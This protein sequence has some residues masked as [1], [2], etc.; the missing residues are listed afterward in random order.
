MKR[1]AQHLLCMA[2]LLFG[3]GG[4][5]Q[6]PDSLGE[7]IQSPQ[8]RKEITQLREK[9]NQS[10]AAWKFIGYSGNLKNRS[11]LVFYDSSSVDKLGDGIYRV[12][13][14]NTKAATIRIF[15]K[16]TE[17]INSATGK[18]SA[19]YVP[20]CA[21]VNSL[22]FNNDH[23]VIV[24]ET[25][26]QEKRPKPNITKLLEIDMKNKKHRAI[27]TAVYK[28]NGDI[29]SRTDP[30]K[31]ENIGLGSTYETLYKILRLKP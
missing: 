2:T 16:D 17:I 23:E 22:K 6:E 10:K 11:D 25:I 7:N 29:D 13:I 28:S 3:T 20:P 24:Y 26:A 5:A 15:E 9:V 30:T 12:W 21:I 18:E 8:L 14:K 1:T 31:W 27:S 4:F 19:G